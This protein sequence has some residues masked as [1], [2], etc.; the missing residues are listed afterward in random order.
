VCEKVFMVH[1]LIIV[2]GISYLVALV[3]LGIICGRL[4]DEDLLDELLPPPVEDEIATHMDWHVEY[5]WARRFR[6]T[7]FLHGIVWDGPT[8]PRPR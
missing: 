5:A 7:G 6:R 3:V 4:P 2:A 8:P 1:T